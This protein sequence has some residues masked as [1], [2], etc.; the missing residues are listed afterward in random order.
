MMESAESRARE[1]R[2]S[3][4]QEAE[5]TR[6]EALAAA[7]R[8]LERID[9]L[10]RPLSD[11][12]IGLRREIDRVTTEMR[13]HGGSG[14]VHHDVVME[15]SEADVERRRDEERRRTVVEAEQRR[16]EEDDRLRSEQE[17]R[18]SRIEAESRPEEEAQP[19]ADAESDQPHHAENENAPEVFVETTAEPDPESSPSSTESGTRRR[20]LLGRLGKKQKIFITEEGACAVCQRTFAAGSQEALDASGWRVSGDVGLCP[21]C[22]A[23][24]WQLPEGARLP[25]RRGSA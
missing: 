17:D 14:D 5:Q 19:E 22:Q 1:I 4:E 13:D 12:V 2:G 15:E 24:G 23:D 20:G 6:S 8:I 3:A 16:R 11:L 25:F 7:G 18:Q 10:E 9:A 21:E